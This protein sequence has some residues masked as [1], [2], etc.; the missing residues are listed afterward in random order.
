MDTKNNI[1]SNT[2]PIIPEAVKVGWYEFANRDDERCNEK[3][4]FLI[5]FINKERKNAECDA[6]WPDL[7]VETYTTEDGT[8]SMNF[9]IKHPAFSDYA[10][11]KTITLLLIEIQNKDPETIKELI[12]VLDIFFYDGI[13]GEIK[14]KYQSNRGR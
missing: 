4:S 12:G 7:V 3:E 10:D 13:P 14:G 5:F 11:I 6:Y 1:N 9:T 2:Y 8:I